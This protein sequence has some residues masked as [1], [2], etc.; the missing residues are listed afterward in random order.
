MR[1]RLMRQMIIEWK[2][3]GNGVMENG[4]TLYIHKTQTQ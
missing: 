1:S 3:E 4:Q 2:E